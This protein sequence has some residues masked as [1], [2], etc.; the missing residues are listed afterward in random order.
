M[1]QYASFGAGTWSE[2]FTRRGTEGISGSGP[3][4]WACAGFCIKSAR[5][6]Q[7]PLMAHNVGTLMRHVYSLP[8][9]R[10]DQTENRQPYH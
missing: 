10:L 9:L 1:G 7:R 5:P 8:V 3:Q 6:R 4:A 2:D